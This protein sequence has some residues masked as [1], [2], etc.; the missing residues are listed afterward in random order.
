M[1][2]R[3]SGVTLPIPRVY[4][5]PY[6]PGPWRPSNGT[7][8]RNFADWFCDGCAKDHKAHLGDLEDG[9]PIYARAIG[10]HLGEPG[11]PSEWVIAE[12]G[13]PACTA[14]EPDGCS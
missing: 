14:F 10:F 3:N 13:Y 9:C 6:P 2:W 1:T 8:G 4:A 12:D 11:Y 7:E 5:N